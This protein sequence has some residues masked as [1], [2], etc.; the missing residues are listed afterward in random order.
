M[1][2]L[3]YA[4]GF[5]SDVE[6][7]LTTICRLPMGL[8]RLTRA[9]EIDAPIASLQHQHHAPEIIVIRIVIFNEAESSH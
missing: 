3:V 4:P 1:R 6:I 2:I 5:I 8:A 9:A 7:G